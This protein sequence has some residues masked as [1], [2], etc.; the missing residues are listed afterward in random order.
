M[1]QSVQ[2]G[3]GTHFIG[4]HINYFSRLD[5]TMDAAREAAIAGSAE[6][7]VILAEEQTSGRGRLERRWLSPRGGLALSIILYPEACHL[8]GLVMVAALAVADAVTMT[9]S[10]KAEIKWPNDVLVG[11]KKIS[12]ILAEAGM[13]TDSQGYA[14]VGLGVNV[15]LNPALYPEIGAIATS[16]S[17]ETGRTHSRVM[18][19][20]ALLTR[21]EYWYEM[22]AGGG[23]VFQAWRNCLTTIGKEVQ[24]L[25][26][27]VSYT[28]VAEDVASDGALLL[29]LKDDRLIK[30]PAGDVTLKASA[31]TP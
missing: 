15:N 29:R 22:L 6:G 21:F 23:P 19:L 8:P 7:T 10:V 4:R 28:G 5:S 26:G 25:A 1:P 2:Q 11:G 27:D 9:T 13:R 20:Q 3:L 16:L 12:G 31:A 30:L 14:V 17:A 24:V 18:V